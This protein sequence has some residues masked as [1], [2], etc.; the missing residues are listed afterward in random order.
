MRVA[1][2]CE[3]LLARGP[4]DAAWLLDALATVGRAGGPPYDLSLLAAIELAGGDRLPYGSRRAIY[5]AADRL[6]LVA[7]KELLFTSAAIEHDKAAAAPRP[8]TP[9]TRPLTLGERKSLARTWKRDVIERLL[10]DPHVDVVELLLRNSRLTET[11]VLRIATAR[12]ASAAVLEL[13]LHAE[14]WNCRPGVRRALLRNPNLPEAAAV[15][16]VGLLNRP[17]LRELDRD[18]T[19]PD[20][21]STAIHR[22][23]HVVFV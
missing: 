21:V 14:R 6:G 1:M 9:G 23:L 5:E 2:L 4:E 16:L 7:C 15:R 3:Q 13:I 22:R 10:V 12:R 18:H 20:S 11:D 17:E 19:L 8:L